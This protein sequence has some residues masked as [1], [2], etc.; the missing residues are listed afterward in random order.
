MN[1]K[2]LRQKEEQ[3]TSILFA[4]SSWI[5]LLSTVYVR[6]G[7]TY[8][9]INY[10]QFLVYLVL[11]F[12][13]AFIEFLYYTQPLDLLYSGNNATN[14]LKLHK[15]LRFIVMAFACTGIWQCVLLPLSGLGLVEY[16][17]TFILLVF[18]LANYASAINVKKSNINFIIKSPMSLVIFQAALFLIKVATWIMPENIY[19]A[20]FTGNDTA[21]WI[22]AIVFAMFLI[23]G[24]KALKREPI[25]STEQKKS[26]IKNGNKLLNKLKVFILS[27]T[28]GPIILLVIAGVGGIIGCI[29]VI[30]IKEDL[31]DLVEPIF[32]GLLSTG[33]YQ[34]QQTPMFVICQIAVF[35]LYCLYLWFISP[36]LQDK[37]NMLNCYTFKIEQEPEVKQMTYEE[38]LKLDEQFKI[39]Y[40]ENKKDFMFNYDACKNDFLSNYIQNTGKKGEI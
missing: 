31:L 13:N 4:C 17:F 6:N 23:S 24:I 28:N 39:Y 40:L 18:M 37:E 35:V 32:K 8:L 21:R 2:T 11:G 1:A 20:M 15:F 38:K 34:I 29:F 14:K 3:L 36:V 12:L 33:K 7:K 5:F 30:K 9:G 26:I 25:L 16:F 22:I 10:I 19:S 27:F